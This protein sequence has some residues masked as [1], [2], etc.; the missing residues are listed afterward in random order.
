MDQPAI[1]RP[2]PKSLVIAQAQPAV[3]NAP[4]TDHLKSPNSDAPVHSTNRSTGCGRQHFGLFAGQCLAAGFGG[5]GLG[6][7]GGGLGAGGGGFGAGGGGLGAAA[8]AGLGG[9]GGAAAGLGGGG[10]ATCLASG[11]AAGGGGV[12]RA[13]LLSGFASGLAS[14]VSGFSS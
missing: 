13:G 3:L 9:G 6:A 2:R 11:F 7:G 10:G 1:L 4:S 5:G 14:L 12:G 8:T